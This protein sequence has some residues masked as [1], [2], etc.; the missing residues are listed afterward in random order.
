LPKDKQDW[1]EA[2]IRYDNRHS[3]FTMWKGWKSQHPISRSWV[4]FE[5][6]LPQPLYAR[7]TYYHPKVNARYFKAQAELA[8]VQGQNNLWF[9]GVYTHDIDCH[10]SAVMS[11]IKVARRLDPMSTHLAQLIAELPSG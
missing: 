2:N 4:T 6:N 1:S 10:E 3:S 7:T 5:D 8:P 9:V 11:A